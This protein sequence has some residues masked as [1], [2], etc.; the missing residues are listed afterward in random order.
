MALF[1]M[2][3]VECCLKRLSAYG[4]IIGDQQS[5]T[6]L[7]QPLT[8]VDV[9]S[10]SASSYLDYLQSLS[11]SE[12]LRQPSLISAETSTV[13]SDL[14]NL[15]FREYPTFISV[16]KCSSAVKSAFDDFS[17]SLEK[18]IGCV[19][20]LEDECQAFSS[21]TSKIQ[22]IRSKASLVQEHQDKLLDLLEIPQLMETCVRNGY[23]Q[24]AME[25]LD[26]SRTISRRYKD[27]VLVQD[28]VR[29]VEGVLQ[30]MLTQL[31]SLLREPIKLPALIKT[32]TFLR[33][34]QALDENELALVFISSRY[35]NFRAQLAYIE[36]DKGD[37]V[38]YLRRYVDLFREHVYDIIAQFT[39]IFLDS[40]NTA[41]HI[42]SFASQ[43]V[44]EL[45][46]LVQTC[47][48]QLSAD[49][50]SMSSI[51]IQLGY[52]VM[53][54][55]RVGLDFASLIAEPF[56]AT[57][58]S[59]FS[60]DI[61]IASKELRELLEESSKLLRPPSEI[62]ITADHLSHVLTAETSPP[63]LPDSIDAV[64]S[65]PPLAALVNAHL[66]ALNSLRL[67]APL[68]LR[69]QIF[70]VHS[71]SLASDSATLLQYFF[72]RSEESVDRLQGRNK[73]RSSHTRTTSAPRVDLLRRNSEVQMT[74]EARAAKKRT[75]KRTCIAAAD[76]WCN[77]VV[78]F[79]V[80]RLA[81]GVFGD[82]NVPVHPELN[83]EIENITG[84]IRE[85][86]E[87]GCTASVVQ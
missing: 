48:P 67:L 64:R 11:L 87:D 35:R 56:A 20:V 29:E 17:D 82:E 81:R 69:A 38:R 9:S 71:T 54:F 52:C 60:H 15:C 31:L 57:C 84:W 30:L 58:L 46:D 32:V 49:A 24:E 2:V 13:E 47:V 36:R 16:H 75:A 42:A 22:R 53:S 12:L 33:R 59:A 28:I 43:A 65:F 86:G 6:A 63:H 21:S 34:L 50:A 68:S 55:T 61:S 8:S 83:R 5:L 85:N 78:P 44:S 74:P 37:P 45:V 62:L 7:L 73:E 51:L 40:P 27:V 10:S 72:L 18:L 79:L 80:E 76:I 25:L 14:T 66:N 3:S 77:I 70:N 4:Y 1:L 23:Y 41:T 26:H 39:T 19:P